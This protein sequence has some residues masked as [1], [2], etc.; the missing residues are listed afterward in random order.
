[1][2]WPDYK[3]EQLFNLE[4]DPYELEDVITEADMQDVIT[5]MRQRHD[6]LQKAALEPGPIDETGERMRGS[7][8]TS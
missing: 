5:E 2:T 4:T 7:A 8:T 1:M 6:E 3:V